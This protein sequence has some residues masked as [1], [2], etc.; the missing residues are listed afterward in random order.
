MKLGIKKSGKY[1]YLYAIKSYR[2]HNGKYGAKT[3]KKFGTV[4]NLKNEL[5]GEDP[6]EWA[7]KMVEYMTLQEKEEKKPVAIN[8][9][10]TA[11]L[12]KDKQQAYNGGYLFLQKI[13]YDLGLHEVCKSISQKYKFEY[14]LNSILS[15]LLYSRILFPASKLATNELSKK[16]IEQPKFDL[17]QIY[18]ALSLLAQESDAIQ[19]SVHKNSLKTIKRQ[20]GVVYYDCTNYFFEVEQAEGLKQYGVSKEHRPNPLVQMG[21]FMD[22]DGI[23][24]AF[25]INPGNTNEQIT[26]RP[27]QKKLRENFDLSEMVVC[28][29]AGLSSL[30]NRKYNDVGS[31][32]FITTQSVKMLKGHIKE[33][34]LS[35][36]GWSIFGSDTTF[37]I[38]QL[39]EER[40]YTDVTFYK[41]RWINENG[42][43]QRILVTFSLKYLNF[44][45]RKRTEQIGRAVDKITNNPSKIN[46]KRGT[47]Y[48]RFIEQSSCT[49]DGE[50]ATINQYSINQQRVMEE[51]QYDG[52]Y[53]VCTNLED[54]AKSIVKINHRRWEI[55]ESFRIMKSEFKAR[56]VYLKRDDRIKAHFL[57]CF[58]SLLIFRILEKRTGS[59]YSPQNLVSTLVEMNFVN[60]ASEGFIPTYTRSNITDDLHHIFDFRTDYQIVS[61]KSMNEIISYTKNS[62]SSQKKRSKIQQNTVK[63]Q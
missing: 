55:E 12:D 57:T 62:R 56:P 28:T 53:A 40:D 9:L 44:T 39:D 11:Q 38:S 17:H 5:G 54:D 4:E 49:K 30:E 50:I 24:L 61:K 21:L 25:D 10:P 1:T 34:A 48:K 35:P 18:R 63:I 45:R 23:P 58:L 47:D 8:L 27:L 19:A 43:E 2:D 60:I 37:N 6:I 22:A 33:W 32:G 46:S 51:E 7:K 16:Y 29:D 36:E 31:R 26:L 42:L 13:Y 14:D 20:T 59:I 3:V 41:E 52:F 15:R